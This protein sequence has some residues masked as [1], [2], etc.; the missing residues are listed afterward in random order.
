M[1]GV[2]EI[3]ILVAYL[4]P[5]G[6]LDDHPLLT[7]VPTYPFEIE[8]VKSELDYHL[9]HLIYRDCSPDRT[10]GRASQGLYQNMTDS[11]SSPRHRSLINIS[12][13]S[14]DETTD[15]YQGDPAELDRHLTSSRKMKVVQIENGGGGYLISLH[16]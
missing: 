13:G 2:W 14:E 4:K 5:Y 16:I 15:T 7:K 9:W 11:D 12:Y 6:I 10:P 1:G 3:L 8:Y